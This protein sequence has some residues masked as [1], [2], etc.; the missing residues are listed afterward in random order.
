MARAGGRV[1]AQVERPEGRIR[2]SRAGSGWENPS[3][4]SPIVDPS[5]L[6]YQLPQPTG[7]VADIFGSGAL[8]LD[9]DEQEWVPQSPDVT[10]K[11]LVLNVTQGYYVNLLRVRTA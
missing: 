3:V 5:K 2:E 11:P 9:G 8:D 6:P 10:F 7:M 4:T 1:A